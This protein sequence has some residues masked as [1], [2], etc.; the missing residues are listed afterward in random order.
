MNDTIWTQLI[1]RLLTKTTAREIVWERSR[2]DAFDTN[3]GSAY[4]RTFE[5][6]AGDVIIQMRSYEDE[7]LDHFDSGAQEM[8]SDVSNA[9]QLL[10]AAR[11]SAL[12]LDEIWKHVL[13]EL[14]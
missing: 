8:E 3:L 12:N 7:L 4:I 14:A 1:T 2:T 5:D 10:D 9:R 11:R 6:R 13:D